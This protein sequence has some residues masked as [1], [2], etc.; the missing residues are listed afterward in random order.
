MILATNNKEKL[1]EIKYNNLHKENNSIKIFHYSGIYSQNQ[2]LYFSWNEMERKGK[3]M[4]NHKQNS[5][6]CNIKK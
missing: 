3:A 4:D 6:L 2:R 1:K 5:K